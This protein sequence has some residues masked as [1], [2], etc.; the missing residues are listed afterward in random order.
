MDNGGDDN[1]A[2]YNPNNDLE[3]QENEGGEYNQDMEGD[4]G[5]G[6]EYDQYFDDQADIG[7]LP[8]DHV[9]LTT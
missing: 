1:G 3:G 4:E 9:R 5:E 2:P 7:Y 8:A 6:E